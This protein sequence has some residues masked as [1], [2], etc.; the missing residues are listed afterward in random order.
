MFY[1]ALEMSKGRSYMR[2]CCKTFVQI[3]HNTLGILIFEHMLN[4]EDR[5]K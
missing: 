2:K 3:L 1:F 4:F 5:L